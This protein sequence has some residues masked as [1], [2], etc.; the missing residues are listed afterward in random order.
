MAGT[1]PTISEKQLPQLLLHPVRALRTPAVGAV[2]GYVV[3]VP[4]HH[5]GDGAGDLAREPLGILRRHDPVLTAVHDED[6]AGDVLCDAL[7]RK[8]RS[9]FLRGGLRLAV[10]S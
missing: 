9:V 4:D 10:T 7:K 3:A 5:Q 2:G 1:S 8:R 6:R